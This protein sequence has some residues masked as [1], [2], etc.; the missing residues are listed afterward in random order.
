MCFPELLQNFRCKQS[1]V[2]NLSKMHLVFIIISF[3]NY[4]DSVF[5]LQI[6]PQLCESAGICGSHFDPRPMFK[7]QG[8]VSAE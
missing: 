2:K 4:T 8:G 1:P 3:G 7:P 6:A 5:W